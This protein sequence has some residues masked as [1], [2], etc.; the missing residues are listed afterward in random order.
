M[1]INTHG[2]LLLASRGIV[3][4]GKICRDFEAEKAVAV[5]G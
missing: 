3:R 5:L 2:M 1:N 4:W